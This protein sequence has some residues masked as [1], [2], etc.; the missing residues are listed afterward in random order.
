[1]GGEPLACFLSLGLPAKLPQ[2][3]VDAFFQGLKRLARHFNVQLAGG[4]IS[5]APKIIADIVIVGQAPLGKSLLRSG[6]RSGDR[7]CVTGK[8]GES[9]SVL[10][11]LFAGERPRAAPSSR[12]FYPMPRIEAG[13][14]LRQ[15][16][17]ATALIDLSDGLSVDLG[18]ICQESGVAATIH[19]AAIPIFKGA[20]L[21]LALHGGED[22]ELL[23]TVPAKTP[24]PAKIAGVNV[25]K[26]GVI[27]GRKDYQPAI[28]ILDENNKE[29]VLEAHGWQHFAKADDKLGG[30]G[31]ESR[32]FS[33][34]RS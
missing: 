10:K 18:H 5:S 16:R 23:F 8:L 20:D 7:I 9:A 13:R 1:M 29:K 33:N 27:Q 12:H 19:A 4:D 15:R 3:W 31:I 26:I 24:V 2:V 30:R 6:A 25:T 22:Y 17:L 21:D 14:W 11:R 34:L 32:N 28:K